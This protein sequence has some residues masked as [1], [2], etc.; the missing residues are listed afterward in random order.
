MGR[1]TSLHRPQQ[2]PDAPAG[3][4]DSLE[5]LLSDPGLAEV[6]EGVKFKVS[7]VGLWPAQIFLTEAT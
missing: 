3:G 2:P 1:N 5:V 4:G 7:P 6:V